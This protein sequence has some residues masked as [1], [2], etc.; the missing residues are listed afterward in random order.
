MY[1]A[2]EDT[3][4]WVYTA[5]RFTGAYMNRPAARA[6]RDRA[7]RMRLYNGK[8]RFCLRAGHI[9]C[10]EE[11]PPETGAGLRAARTPPGGM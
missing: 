8:A 2:P 10:G 3:F 1:T 5:F 4:G 9:C 7:M 11:S 6:D